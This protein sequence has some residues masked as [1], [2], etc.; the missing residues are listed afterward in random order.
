MASFRL[1]LV[2]PQR[3]SPGF[4]RGGGEPA[5]AAVPLLAAGHD[6]LGVPGTDG[7]ALVLPPN[8]E[9]QYRFV[10][11][12]LADLTVAG[13]YTV[14]VKRVLPDGTAVP[15]PLERF[16]SDN[17]YERL[18]VYYLQSPGIIG[19]GERPVEVL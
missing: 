14:Q 11:S 6:L 9:R 3:R 4:L 10:L 19:P 1:S 7:A 5:V 2:G 15:A 12:R 17:L 13:N 8:G 18:S 16:R